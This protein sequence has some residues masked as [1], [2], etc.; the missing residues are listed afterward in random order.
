MGSEGKA[1]QFIA[2]ETEGNQ[3]RVAPARRRAH[4]HPPQAVLGT[5]VKRELRL[6]GALLTVMVVVAACGSH[7]DSG[8]NATAGAATTTPAAIAT[9]AEPTPTPTPARAVSIGE[10]FV[11]GGMQVTIRSAKYACTNLD[12]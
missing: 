2:E 3:H 7:A 5:L 1:M 8:A 11:V 9:T 4:Q 6:L 12:L 10:P